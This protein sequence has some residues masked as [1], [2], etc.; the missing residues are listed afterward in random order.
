MHAP[1]HRD[2]LEAT[3]ATEDQVAGVALGG[4]GSEVRDLLVR[5]R[6]GVLDLF[7]QVAETGAENQAK[8][9]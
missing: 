6:L 9:R 7:R 2:D 4:R 8:S 1:L 5:D 3:E